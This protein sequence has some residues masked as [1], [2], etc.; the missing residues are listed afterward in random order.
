MDLQLTGRKAFVSGST[1]G[2]GLAIATLLAAEGAEVVINGRSD[3]SV[4]TALEQIKCKAPQAKADGFFGDQ[5]R[6]F[7]GGRWGGE[8][9]FLRDAIRVVSNR[10]R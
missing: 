6:G 9:L 1:K 8:V 7:A 3:E 5:R 4:A 10:R 2:I